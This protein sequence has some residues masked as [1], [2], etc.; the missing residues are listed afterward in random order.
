[1]R[2]WDNVTLERQQQTRQ[3][4]SADGDKQQ[5][6]LLA[7]L[8]V[9]GKIEKTATSVQLQTLSEYALFHY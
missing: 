8:T 3:Q 9:C 4:K 1:M 7:V 2:A 6:P 5:L